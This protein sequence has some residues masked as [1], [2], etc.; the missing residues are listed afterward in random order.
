MNV[1]KKTQI[2]IWV[3]W[4]IL[5][6]FAL[7]IAYKVV[8]PV[9]EFNALDYT[10]FILLMISASMI[11]IV[12]NGS[13]MSFTQWVSLVIFLKFGLFAEIIVGQF[14]VLIVM[15]RV[16]LAKDDWYKYALNSSMLL[17]ISLI[18]ASI[19]YLF[20]GNHETF[21]IGDWHFIILSGIYL[22]T[23]FIL[24]HLILISVHWLLFKNR[25][26]LF[27]K[28][29]IWESLSLLVSMP[30]GLIL[31][32]LYNSVGIT[33]VLLIGIPVVSMLSIVNIYNDSQQKN[34]YLKQAVEV[35]HLLTERL[36]TD[37]VIEVFVQ[38]LLKLF[39]S[40]Y[41]YVLD[42]IN[43]DRLEVI[44]SYEKGEYVKLDIPPMK[45][46]EGIAG[47]A[48]GS[49]KTLLYKE[50][51]EWESIVSGY[52][53][54]DAESL[55]VVPIM[56]NNDVTGVIF[57][58]SS[59]KRRYEK[60]H[61]M[62]VD[63]LCSYFAI[64]VE[65]ARHYE[66][67]KLQSERDSL[68]NLFNARVFNEKLEEACESLARGEIET[69]S[70]L[71]V[72]IDHF[73]LVND[74]YGH[75]SGNEV[76]VQLADLLR[77]IVGARGIIS[78][79]GGEEFAILLP[80]T[81]KSEAILFGEYIRETIEN[82]AFVMYDDL[83]EVRRKLTARITVSIG[84]ACSPEDTDDPTALIRYADRALYIGAKRVGRNKVADY[85]S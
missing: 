29:I 64:A 13:A 26:P 47:L 46:N 57:L 72:D 1:T 65:N 5:F 34:V 55:L 75:E 25:R 63:I 48:W 74:T 45:K 85:V 41:L 44:R 14:V 53:P 43:G 68:T 50:K 4:A 49:E 31:Y 69:L 52:I 9:P 70:V 33:S 11:T 18:S 81:P 38:N 59:R 66:K 8:P 80:N 79:Y 60:F 61:L 82:R 40:D 51:K 76:L 84:V 58:G 62:I 20:G 32:F 10:I 77:N 67:T 37:E 17:V 2:F 42:N 6:P 22:V 78:R 23:W 30:L 71:L 73:K 28:D 7:W 15:L 54:E 21:S 3:F 56:K 24:N 39:P 16:R 27:S 12:V 83:S 36:K 19:F 35:G